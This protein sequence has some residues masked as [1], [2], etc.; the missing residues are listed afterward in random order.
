M[1]MNASKPILLTVPMEQPAS[2]HGGVHS[3]FV[4]EID[5]GQHASTVSKQIIETRNFA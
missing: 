3:V 5:M 2:T 4:L 1:S